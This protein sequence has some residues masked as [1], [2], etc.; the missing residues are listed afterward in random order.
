[1]QDVT[2][3]GV[4]FHRLA[5]NP[6]YISGPAEVVGIGQ[7]T[8]LAVAL[9]YSWAVGDTGQE[10]V[11]LLEGL[12]TD[13]VL[14]SQSTKR[15]YQALV[16]DPSLQIANRLWSRTEVGTPEKFAH[17]DATRSGVLTLKGTW[18][19][20]PPADARWAR[21]REIHLLHTPTSRKQRGA[22]KQGSA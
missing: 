8:G 17:L 4:A 11:T 19:P 16:D 20:R 5:V 3:R 22:K 21:G 6:P 1:M 10:I 14:L 9:G 12:D 13:S 2:G 18:I 15:G 7:T